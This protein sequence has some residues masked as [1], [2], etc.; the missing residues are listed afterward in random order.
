M[1]KCMFLTVAAVVLTAAPLAM[2][3]VDKVRLRNIASGDGSLE[4]WPDTYGAWSFWGWSDNHDRYNPQGNVG[5]NFVSF[6]AHMMIYDPVL[7]DR[8][9]LATPGFDIDDTYNLGERTLAYRPRSEIVASDSSGNGLN[10]TA[11]SSFWVFGTEPIS[12]D[13]TLR[14]GFELEQK[15]T[16]P[17]GNGVA[18]YTKV[19][20]ITN[21]GANT[22]SIE[23][24]QH[25]DLDLLF[26]GDFKDAAGTDSTNGFRN[27]YMQEP[28]T[29]GG[30]ASTKVAISGSG[31]STY[32]AGRTTDPAQ[33]GPRSAVQL[34]N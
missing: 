7:Q 24:H 23:F 1:R 31:G 3:Q 26:D 2:A 4:V 8:L 5:P 11:N 32:S 13:P 10:D 33:G 9:A 20:T 22:V 28:D 12:G 14:L 17:D 29:F 19:Y 27:A 6:A 25:D 18:T 30:N 15:V 16:G 21:E 34:R